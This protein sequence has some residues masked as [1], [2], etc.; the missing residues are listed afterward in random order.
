MRERIKM[1]GIREEIISRLLTNIKRDMED[2]CPLTYS[3]DN[4]TNFIEALTLE[5]RPLN[6]DA[7]VD[8]SAKQ[9]TEAANKFAKEIGALF[10]Q[11]DDHKKELDDIFAKIAKDISDSFNVFKA[12]ATPLM[13]ESMT[14]K[15]T[16]TENEANFLPVK[17]QEFHIYTGN[18]P[19][20]LDELPKGILL[21]KA[22]FGGTAKIIASG[23]ASYGLLVKDNKYIDRADVG[24][25]PD[26]GTMCVNNLE[27]YQ[28]A[29]FTISDW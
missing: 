15:V 3:I 4:F 2:D 17:G 12:S 28:D 19:A 5:A 6:P 21:C 25:I 7:E 24:R 11:P 20:T 8:E 23:K 1:E 27:L 14:A 22:I 29:Y 13:A 9:Q 16:D 18:P 26:K 10:L